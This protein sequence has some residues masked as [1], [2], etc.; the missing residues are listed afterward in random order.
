[1][2][3]LRNNVIN[4]IILLTI[5]FLW[6]QGIASNLSIT[7]INTPTI[8]LSSTIVLPSAIDRGG[9]SITNLSVTFTDLDAVDIN[10]FFVT[11][12]VRAP[13]N[14]SIL[15]IVENSQHGQNGVTIVDNGSGSY[16]AD[17]NWDP[18]DNITL[19]YYDLYAV[20]S[21][22]VDSDPDFFD[23]NSDELL[24]TNG[25]ENVSPIIASDASY[26]TPAGV[27]RIGGNVTIIGAQFIDADMPG[28][29]AF[30]V[31]IKLRE[32][33]NSSE[34]ILADAA[35]NVTQG[36]T[37]SDEGSGI[38]RVEV[39]W[40]PPDVQLLGY[41]DICILI[42]D[43]TATSS[44]DYANNSDEFE[45][46]DAITNNAPTLTS[47]NTF[48][49]PTS[50]NRIGSE[51]IMIK[52]AFTDLDMSGPSTFSISIKVRDP[53]STE[54]TIVNAAKH[55]EQ[56]LFVRRINGS[57]Y[58]ASVLWEPPDDVVTGTYD[59]YFYVEDDHAANA[60]DG[61][62]N[63]IDELTVTS[64]SILGDG[65]MLRRTN[66]AD[67]CGGANSACHNI[68]NHQN[69]DC[70][71]CHTSHGSKNIYLVR[72][73][74]ATPNSGDKSVVFKT[75]GIG[76]PYN[77]PD[78]IIGDP[79]S[80]VMA[81]STNAVFTGVCEVCHTTTEHH[82]NDGS[83]LPPNHHDG[84]N[85][86]GC[87]PHSEGFA[88][89]E[90]TG[91][92]ACACH[93]DIFTSMDS[94]SILTRHILY[95]DDADYFPP[96]GM[97][98]SK[99]CLS[100]HVDHNIFRADL[101]PGVGERA[102][103]LRV[104]KNIEP[105]IGDNTTLLNSDYQSSGTGGVCLSCHDTPDMECSSCHTMFMLRKA[106]FSPFATAADGSSV[107]RYVI[108]TSFDAATSTHNYSVP[109]IYGADGSQ[110]NAN[111]TK[112]HND[113]MAKTYQSSSVKV[114]LHGSGTSLLLDST[115][116]VSPGEFLEENFCFKCHSTISN[117]NAGSNL[118]F[119][120]VQGMA[121]SA[122]DI[123]TEFG[124]TYA[125]QV[126]NYSGIHRP[127]E[128]ISA[129]SRHVEGADCHN[130]HEATDGTHDG[131]SQ[132][133]SNPLKGTWGVEP[134]TWP[135]RPIPT[136]NANLF[137]APTGYD[138][139]GYNNQP[140]IQYEYQICLKCHSNYRTL[141]V[142]SRN[143]AEEINPNYPSTHGIT[144]ANQN[145]YCNS[146]TMFEPWGASGSTYCS[147]CHRSDIASDPE[148]PHG[149]NIEHLLVASVV[150]NSTVGTPLCNVCHRS[151]V[152]WNGSA[153][154]S[155]FPQHPATRSAHRYAQ[156]C[157][158]CHM[159]DYASTSGLGVSTTSWAG[160][161]PDFKIL[162][163][164]Q[165]KRWNFRDRDGSAGSGQDADAFCNG[166]LSDMDYTNRDCWSEVCR[167]HS[168]TGY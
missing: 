131:S 132:L 38:Y 124:Y 160:G 167:T 35:T 26:A 108:K 98:N 156:G 60:E 2:H 46:Y 44:D 47:G 136:D 64:S 125:H 92:V 157:F 70:I 71:V 25:G 161:N 6:S 130:V 168:G 151:S 5:I 4:S 53:L 85:C 119:F 65:N 115:G 74:I 81:D 139:I 105:L 163:H 42:N 162:I 21:D 104:D 34:I 121:N 27:D 122:L 45:I 100:C 50:V 149:S 142:D 95:D 159:W 29:N 56:G 120:G 58:E 19:G 150:S 69:Q 117:P 106:G 89:S 147:D 39:S 59:L 8:T 12:K 72:E 129:A 152:Y 83:Q 48:A 153:S 143:I 140:P 101:N 165:N 28:I 137:V 52:T 112:C 54:Y 87:H 57:Y 15:P 14:E 113:D 86:V 148:G 78:P 37:I 107:H 135:V 111:C 75:T 1:M 49:L 24:I 43:G 90:S 66:N 62:A 18:S 16:T 77:D 99:N 118:D 97:Y 20:I 102:Y 126:G 141:P 164:G 30:T 33:D 80:G 114:S 10:S 91:G 134:L 82:R 41:Y 103:N 146:T 73:T 116:V 79:T 128:D 23:D 93:G 40:D 84:E 127:D 63:N 155:R 144:I 67:N 96:Y 76:D 109:V 32:P 68:S 133:I 3:R 9:A 166:Y 158:A 31:T 36:V 154:S 61:Y 94:T 13:Y 22:G 110:F 123:E 11:I 51:F 17:V 7:Q 138:V 55:S 88:V 145:S